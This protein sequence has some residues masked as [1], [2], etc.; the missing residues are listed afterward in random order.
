MILAFTGA[1]ISKA[2]GIPTF[3][4]LGV[5][6]NSLS[7]TYANQ[8]PQEYEEFIRD[9]IGFCRNAK[10]N[11]AHYALAE[12]N[13]P[14]ITMNIDELHK[15]AGSQNV[16]EIHGTLPKDPTNASL[17]VGTPILYGDL[18][19][20]YKDAVKKVAELGKG[21]VF[22]VIGASLYTGISQELREIAY[23]NGATIVE[24]NDNAEKKVR[25]YLE[26]VTSSK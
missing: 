2:S 24:I 12:Y 25:D 7:R 3:E 8:H 9:L 20:L 26:T 16:L 11:D 15:R 21:D 14:I 17:L 6:R 4:E 23:M 1:G 18:A 19:P 22:L 5:L 13:I 10:P